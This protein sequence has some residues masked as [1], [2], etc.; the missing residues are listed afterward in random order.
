MK[1]LAWVAMV[2]L[3]AMPLVLAGCESKPPP[4]KGPPTEKAP[5][6]MPP[7]PPSPPPPAG[8]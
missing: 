5:S 4:E 7:T 1:Y 3:V 6:D 2:G 8:K